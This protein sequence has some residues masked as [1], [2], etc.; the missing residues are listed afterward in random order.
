ML[1]EVE[2]IR[3]YYEEHKRPTDIADMLKVSKPY[4]TKVIQKDDRY[5]KE[6]E[7]RSSISKE[8]RKESKRNDA[9][10]RRKQAKEEYQAIINQINTDNI[11]VSRQTRLSNIEFA[12]WNRGA[13]K[14]DKVSGD[15]ILRDNINAGYNAPKRVSNIVN[16]DCIKRAV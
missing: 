12:K 13:Y 10:K 11:I 15:L 3:L 6:K 14:Q 7:F 9:R 4:I 1:K 2:I 5:I 8:K 16:A